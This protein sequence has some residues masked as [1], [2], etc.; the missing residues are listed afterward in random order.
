MPMAEQNQTQLE[1]DIIQKA[2]QTTSKKMYKPKLIKL[3]HLSTPLGQQ[4]DCASCTHVEPTQND[5]YS[6]PLFGPTVLCQS[7]LRRLVTGMEAWSY[8]CTA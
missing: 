2:E 3:R 8:N 5:N 7:K 1:L 6:F 4:M